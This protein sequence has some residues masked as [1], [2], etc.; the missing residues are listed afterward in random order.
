MNI[1]EAP[2]E[3]VN[4]ENRSSAGTEEGCATAGADGS[5]SATKAFWRTP[6]WTP[7]GPPKAFNAL[8][9]TDTKS[10]SAV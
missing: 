3:Y 1:S 2:L 4:A 10:E 8:G 6:S 5:A 9:T 7:S